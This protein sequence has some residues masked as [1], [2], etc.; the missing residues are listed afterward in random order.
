MPPKAKKTAK[1]T[2][3]KPSAYNCFVKKW[4]KEHHSDYKSHSPQEMLARAAR[5]W[6]GKSGSSFHYEGS[7]MKKRRAKLVAV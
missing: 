3:R 7:G 5:A 1:K 4:L 2:C 6:S